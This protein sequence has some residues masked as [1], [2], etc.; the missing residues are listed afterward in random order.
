MPHLVAEI[1]RDFALS[2]TTGK[3]P[4]S[5]NSMIRLAFGLALASLGAAPMA[6][7]SSRQLPQDST[8]GVAP[9]F[10]AYITSGLSNPIGIMH[11]GD[12]SGR[13]F[14][15]QQSGTVRVVVNNVLQTPPLLTLRNSAPITQCRAAP[16][17]PLANVGFTNGG[18][19]GLLGLAFHPNFASN[20]QVFVSFT[21]SS[22]DSYVS[23]YTMADPTA[24]VMTTTDLESCVTVVRV[25]QDYSNHNGGGIAFGPDGY[26]YFGLGDGGDGGDPCERGQTISPTQLAANDGN[27]FGCPSD[28]S[29]TGSG[30]N[31][32]SRALLGSM[33][34]L[35]IDASTP[36]GANGLCASA[37]GGSANYAIPANNPY[38]GADPATG[39]DEIWAW[40]LRNPWRWSFDRATG[41]LFIGDVGQGTQE[42]VS[43]EP[44]ASSGGLNFGWNLCEGTAFHA[45][46]G[47]GT[48]G[49][50]APIIT[51]AR[52]GGRCAITGGY[53]YRG[54]VL[55]VQGRY[56]FAD[57]CSQQIWTSTFNGAT[58]T[59]PVGGTPFQTMGDLVT[60]FG[61]DEVGHLYVARGSQIWRLAGAESQPPFV[62]A[63]I[64]DQLNDAGDSVSLDV[65]GNFDDPESDPL[66]FDATGLPPGLTISPNGL[67]DGTID[68]G[69]AGVYNVSVSADDGFSGVSDEFTWTV[70][71]NG[72]PFVVAPLSAQQSEEGAVIA[73]DV[74]G[75]FDDPE[76]DVL[77]FSAQGLPTG[78][79]ITPAGLIQGT[80]QAGSA[81]LFIV[82]VTAADALNQAEGMFTWD[83]TANAAPLLVA[84]IADQSSEEGA[85]V[86]LDVAGNFDDPDG[87]TLGFSATGLPPGL[88]ISGTG[89]IDGVI[90]PGAAGE[91][92]VVVTAEDA[93]ESVSDSFT[94]TVTESGTAIFS[95]GF[96]AGE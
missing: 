66:E 40:G 69:A 57:Y 16:A 76:G 18:E 19:R 83:V 63:P 50:T 58:W 93:S 15:I 5:R 85:A 43:F 45:G 38:V 52:S 42:E 27:D 24:N 91:Y 80:I 86:L 64:A 55:D 67:I 25:D 20:G 6:S 35:D 84:P 49:L 68:L 30:G 73:L 34:R 23:R 29:F 7:A 87:D 9:A 22:G 37:A 14:I 41:D 65:A 81:G 53:R 61:E 51:Y 32:N 92:L 48:V 88:N 62:V 56:F 31:S 79:D 36:A 54:P 78:L 46:S 47:C 60:S 95:S 33:L 28:A 94:W 21:D 2:M 75:N 3:L 13:V 12:G 70:T 59:Q 82:T 1:V 72:A 17:S 39:C 44:A 4:M 89:T 26:L 71:G 8:E 90:T 10:V 11:A 96:E 77:T 74:S